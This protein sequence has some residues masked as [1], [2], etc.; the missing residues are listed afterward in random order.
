MKKLLVLLAIVMMLLSGCSS[1]PK[2]AI[3]RPSKTG[4]LQV[5][6][7][8][9]TDAKGNPVMLRGISFVG[10]SLQERYINE[11]T[12]KTI[13]NDMKC[14]VV[15]MALYTYG[16]GTVGYCTGKNK[17]Q[18]KQDI[19][20][21]VELAEKTDM[22][23]IVDWH[24]LTDK[25]PN[26]YIEDAKDFFNEMSINFKDKKNV[27]YEICNEPNGVDWQTIKDYANVII[28]IIRE[29]DPDSLII[30]GTPNWSSDIAS[31]LNDPLDYD[32]LMYT[33]HFYSASVK[34]DGRAAARA[35]FEKGLP[36]FVTEFGITNSNGNFPI[37]EES[38]DEWIKLLEEFNVS[39]VMWSFST[40]P[41][42]SAAIKTGTL[43]LSNFTEDQYTTSGKWLI[44]TIETWTTPK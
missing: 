13:A 15:R 24:I 6:D 8:K 23:C 7:S 38:A 43:N 12:F 20:N 27:I 9:L 36:V 25:D 22:Y 28:P 30:C 39:Y 11:D 44:N 35:V 40:S 19:V 5:T 31:A 3:Q 21:A 10:V 42:A 29:N 4:Q 26:R 16:M 41:E 37:D 17:E 33:L 32:N 1:A 34:E 2:D 14:N 18:L